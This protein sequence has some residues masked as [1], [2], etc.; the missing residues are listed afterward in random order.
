MKHNIAPHAE[1]DRSFFILLGPRSR[2]GPDACV[3]AIQYLLYIFTG[4]GAPRLFHGRV[5]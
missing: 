5:I 2:A 3:R 4:P 1:I